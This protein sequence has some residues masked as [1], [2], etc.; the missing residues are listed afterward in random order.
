M[1]VIGIV[2]IIT[3]NNDLTIHMVRLLF[4]GSNIFMFICIKLKLSFN[5]T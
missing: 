3:T 2:D 4:L 5:L 1:I